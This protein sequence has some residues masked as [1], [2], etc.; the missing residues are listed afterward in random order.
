MSTCRPLHDMG[1]THCA[2]SSFLM[3]HW[4]GSHSPNFDSLFATPCSFSRFR[5]AITTLQPTDRIKIL[6]TKARCR[7]ANSRGQI[8]SKPYFF[9]PKM[10][11]LGSP[12]HN[13]KLDQP[14]GWFVIIK[15]LLILQCLYENLELRIR[16]G[17]NLAR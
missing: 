11:C 15:S 6:A 4:R 10:H 13:N 14:M 1:H 7:P 2:S 3:L 17:P 5:D 16:F 12:L 9:V 8:P